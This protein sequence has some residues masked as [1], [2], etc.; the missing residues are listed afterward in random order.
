M[1]CRCGCFC[2]ESKSGFHYRMRMRKTP[3]ESRRGS[4]TASRILSLNERALGCFSSVVAVSSLA[5]AYYFCQ[6]NWTDESGG[7]AQNNCLRTNWGTEE[8]ICPR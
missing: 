2:S 4:S 6:V 3:L 1:F 7:K 8:A 5:F